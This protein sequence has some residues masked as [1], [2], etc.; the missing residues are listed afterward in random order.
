MH[1]NTAL[2]NVTLKEKLLDVL[3]NN[4][5]RPVVKEIEF[6]MYIYGADNHLSKSKNKGGLATAANF[7]TNLYIYSIV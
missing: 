3:K 1:T 2:E 5:L 6:N 4:N 7:C